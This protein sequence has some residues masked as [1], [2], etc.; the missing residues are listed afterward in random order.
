MPSDLAGTRQEIERSKASAAAAEA[1]GAEQN[2]S[3]IE[4][5]TTRCPDPSFDFSPEQVGT[6]QASVSGIHATVAEQ[7]RAL[8]A[9][10]Q[11]AEKLCPGFRG[12]P[13]GAREKVSAYPDN[14]LGTGSR[15]R[16]A[17][18]R[19][20]SRSPRRS[21]VGRQRAEKAVVDPVAVHTEIE[22]LKG[23]LASEEAQRA[24]EARRATQQEEALAAERQK[25]EKS[26]A[27]VVSARAEIES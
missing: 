19:H 1:T 4:S 11:K 17:G 7:K 12:N 2:W 20:R 23:W 25:A 3:S 10:Q 21:H 13:G 6:V 9:E 8:D 14:G 15:G 18:R 16:K 26:L 24:A 27:D 22:Q 5:A